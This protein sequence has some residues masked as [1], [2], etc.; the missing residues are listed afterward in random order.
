[1]Y[2]RMICANDED[3]EDQMKTEDLG[4]WPQIVGRGNSKDKYKNI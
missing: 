4:G 2:E 3:A 1:M